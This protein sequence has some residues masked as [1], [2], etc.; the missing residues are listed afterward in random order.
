MHFKSPPTRFRKRPVVITAMQYDGDNALAVIE[1]MG[2]P[3]AARAETRMVPGPGRGMHEALVIHTLEG[4]MRAD[5]GDW[6]IC[7]VSGEHYP[8]KPSIFDATYE[9]AED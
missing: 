7:G 3:S 9:P 4:D 6:I 2:G 1:F 5:P 8:C